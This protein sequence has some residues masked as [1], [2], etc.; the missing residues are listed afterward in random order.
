[1]EKYLQ[2]LIYD[3]IVVFKHFRLP[4]NILHLT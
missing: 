3:F 1:M 4:L 2:L